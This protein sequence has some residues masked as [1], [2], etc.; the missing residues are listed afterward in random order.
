MAPKDT[1]STEITLVANAREYLEGGDI[2]RAMELYTKA[3]DPDALDEEEARSMLIEGRSSLS[4][5]FLSEALDSFEEAL[6]M[7]TDVQRRQALDGILTVANISS[8]LE[9]LGEQLREGLEQIGKPLDKIGLAIAPGFAN[10][11]LIT[12]DALG[13][14]PGTLTKT[15][16]ISRVP[17]HMLERDLPIN[18]DKCIPYGDEDDVRYILDVVR[19]LGALPD[20]EVSP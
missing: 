9:G 19:F 3:H 15:A 13:K 5:K 16:R 14:L 6:V 1:E 12:N 7:G 10:V 11:F 20:P 18:A 2:E 4:K 8:R 17:Q